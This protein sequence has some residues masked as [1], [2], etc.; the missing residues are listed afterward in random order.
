MKKFAM[1]LITLLLAFGFT[2]VSFAHD[3]DHHKDDGSEKVTYHDGVTTIVKTH[4]DVRYDKIVK[5]DKSSEY[6]TE[7]K[8]HKST[9]EK[10]DVRFSKEYH[11]Q[12]DWYSDVKTRTTYEVTK[13]VTW[14]EVTRYD[15][16]KVFTTPVK[17]IKTTV[18]TIKH[19]GK[20]GSGGKVFYKDTET[21]YDKKYG[22][23]EYKIFKEKHVMN[24]NYKTTYTKKVI[25][26][27]VSKGKWVKNDPKK[28]G[29][30]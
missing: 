18:T 7:K 28:G 1:I 27:E 24:K 26:V 16:I 8:Y 17:I 5:Y 25:D 14:D 29:H 11:P 9:F 2:S 30:H 12:K 20:P 4:K 10:V 21:Y 13:H 6:K 22:K 19:Y 3:D 15:T 23:T